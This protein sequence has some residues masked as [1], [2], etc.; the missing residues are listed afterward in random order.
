MT[1]DR[2]YRQE[3]EIAE[4]QERIREVVRRMRERRVGA[5]VVVDERNR[6]VGMLT[7][8]D[9]AIRVVGEERDPAVT[10]VE[11]V[12][13]HEPCVVT[14]DM[15]I[16]AALALMGGQARSCRRL[17][18]I[19]LDGR[20]LGIVAV[21]DALAR[22]ARQLDAIDRIVRSQTPFVLNGFVAYEDEAP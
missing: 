3:V 18:V 11:D 9:V 7:D 20:L 21:D 17:P 8:R 14:A 2:I 12:M 6:P 4:P 15:P 13:T 5:V 19:D 1:V 16:E 22:I 10:R